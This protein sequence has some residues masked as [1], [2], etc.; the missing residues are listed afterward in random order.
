LGAPKNEKKK[1]KKKKDGGNNILINIYYIRICI[2]CI[3]VSM[4]GLKRK[5][6]RKN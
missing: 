1:K 6:K 2:M 4:E 3:E 5:R